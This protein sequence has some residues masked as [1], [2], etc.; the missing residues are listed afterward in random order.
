MLSLM[1]TGA[2]CA[3]AEAPTKYPSPPRE[4]RAVWVATVANIDWPSKKGLPAEKQKAELLDILDK[5]KALRLNA[6]VFQI[7]PMCDALYASK[8]EPWSE[9]LTGQ[10]GKSPGY[11]PLEFAVKEAH[12]RGLEL[13]AWFNPYRA[14]TPTA[15]SPIVESHIVKK[16]PELAPRYG[17]HHWMVPT[18]KEVQDQSMAVFLD[19]VN[20]YD[21]DGIHID[22]YFYPYKEKGDD[23]KLIP[24]P[25]DADWKAYQASGGKLSRDDWRR[26][27]VNKFVERM[28]VETK[29]AKPHVKVGI[30]PFGIWRPNNPP[31]IQGFDQYAEL[32]ADAKLWLNKGWVDY[33][34][35]QLYWPIQKKEQSYPRLLGWWAGENSKQRHLWPGNAT[36]RVGNDPKLWHA[37]ELADQIR[38]TRAQ[39]GAS[40]NV[41]FSMKSL[42]NNRVG[43]TDSIAKMYA[44]PALVPASP[45]LG[46]TP[47]AKPA[48]SRLERKGGLLLDIQPAGK[49]VRLHVVR[50]LVGDKWSVD[51]V[52]ATRSD[53]KWSSDQKPAKVVVTSIDRVGQESEPV[54]LTP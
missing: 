31:G 36:Y 21:V 20:R 2:L 45:W 27:A 10:M 34:T 24:F 48:V 22:D 18:N 7:R 14:H 53:N 8:L 1:L 30:S 26:D 15:K 44:E 50:Q 3:P 23:G 9:Y 52:S 19:V 46:K 42:M 49:D 28:Y 29:K 6:I 32:Y 4:F 17:K 51:I 33:W 5:A 11:D 25:D 40:G 13:H 35:P 39:K 12:A 54:E 43:V 16:R 37:N 38:A 41:H 47:P